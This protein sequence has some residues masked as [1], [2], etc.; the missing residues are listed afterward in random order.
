MMKRDVGLKPRVSKDLPADK[1][2]EILRGIYPDE[3][4]QELFQKLTKE[5]EEND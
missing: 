1:L 5:G 3:I 4:A 2:L